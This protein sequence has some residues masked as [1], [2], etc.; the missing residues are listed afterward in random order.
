MR[1][2]GQAITRAIDERT[3]S[4]YRGK[5]RLTSA[6]LKIGPNSVDLTLGRF[7]LI[8]KVSLFAVDPER[9]TQEEL[10]EPLESPG[11]T[12]GVGDFCLAAVQ[13]RFD[14]SNPLLIADPGSRH[15]QFVSQV[16]GRSTWGR[17]GLLVH[18]TAGYGD[19]GFAGAYTL[20]LKNIGFRPL[21]LREGMRIAQISFQEVYGPLSY[22]GA[23]SQDDHFDRPVAPRLGPGR[24]R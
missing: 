1:L 8:P 10:F 19:Y 21:I 18:V 16:D 3:W 20:E 7:F 9:E 17:L 11:L 22:E 2:G 24:F 6:D 23:Y 15:A 12:L 4:V 5:E 14:C 13:E